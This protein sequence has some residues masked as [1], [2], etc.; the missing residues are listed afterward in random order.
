MKKYL[1]IIALSLFL[2]PGMIKHTN[3][4]IANADMNT[5]DSIQ[6]EIEQLTDLKYSSKDIKKI[7]KI[8]H[9]ESDLYIKTYDDRIVIGKILVND[10]LSD[11]RIIELD[12]ETYN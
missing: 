4:K 3:L 2:I 10:D 8:K 5:L 6:H 7:I 9:K 12:K 1:I 11:V